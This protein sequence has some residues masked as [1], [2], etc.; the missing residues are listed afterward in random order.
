MLNFLQNAMLNRELSKKGAYKL[1]KIK[2]GEKIPIVSNTMFNTMINNTK[3]KKYAA[4]L[5]SLVLE[6]DYQKVY[7][8]LEFQKEGIDREKEIHQGKTVDFICKIDNE[9]ICIEMNNN[10]SSTKPLSRNISY[11]SDLYKAGVN[12]G[13]GY[14][15]NK[16]IQININNFT[17]KGNDET[18]E[19][20]YIGNKKGEAFTDKLVF[21]QIYIPNIKK[22]L[23][24]GEKLSELEKLILVFNENDEE[25]LKRLCGGNEIMED[26]VKEAKE[27][28]ERD[29]IIGLY[30]KEMHLE[31]IRI[32]EIEDARIEGLEQGVKQGI[33]RGIKQDKIEIAKNMLNDNMDI[34]IISKYT[35]LSIKEI[36]KLK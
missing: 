15:Y 13:T 22:K 5:I 12:Q 1:E 36:E 10:L 35:G 32:S 18:L 27:A 21:F 2:K 17:F 29:E 3:R 30:D 24:N 33:K 34:D 20:Y 26:Y 23:Y 16:V 25:N 31:N 7:D 11:A 9:I 19:V 14:N 4:Y 6:L 28:S 8:G